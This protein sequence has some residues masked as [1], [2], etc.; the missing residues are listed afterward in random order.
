MSPIALRPAAM[1]D[2]RLMFDWVNRP[3]S[4][5]EKRRTSA[6]IPLAQH[7]S[8]FERMLG[9]PQCQIWIVAS[10][11][12]PVGQ[13]RLQGRAEAPEID[14][15]IAAE[16]R[17]AGVARQAVGEAIGLWRRTCPKARPQAWVRAGNRASLALFRA[18]AFERVG[19]ADGFIRLEQASP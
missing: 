7:R 15:Y 3:D 6:P 12:A 11:G 5:A 2:M 8:W 1:D 9:D 18:L 16:A 17:G 10:D 19:E 14:V 13:V 4:L